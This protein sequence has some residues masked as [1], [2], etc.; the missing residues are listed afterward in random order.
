M[1]PFLTRHNLWYGLKIQVLFFKFQGVTE[2]W[3]KI[4]KDSDGQWRSGSD[5][6][7]RFAIEWGTDEPID[8]N[9]ANCAVFSKTKGFKLRAVNCMEPKSFLC[10]AKAPNCPKG[11]TWVPSVGL[12]R[13]C[14]KISPK[15]LAADKDS[16]GTAKN[17]YDVTLAD[18]Y[19]MDKESRLYVPETPDEVKQLFDWVSK[20]EV[21]PDVSISTI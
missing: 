19:C 13:S 18:K 16:S 15:L 20:P 12:G 2:I 7:S 9:G 6:F 5:P 17:L 10:M 8:A 1:T 4:T 21:K 11:F 14:Y 3:T